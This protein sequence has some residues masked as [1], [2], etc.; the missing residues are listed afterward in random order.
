MSRPAHRVSVFTFRFAERSRLALERDL[1]GTVPGD[2]L[3]QAIG[4]FGELLWGEETRCPA[5]EVDEPK[6]TI[7]HHCQLADHR[8]FAAQRIDIALDFD[9]VDVGEDF[10]VAELTS[11]ATKRDVQVQ[12]QRRV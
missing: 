4:Q 12:A 1:F 8:D 6:R 10:E 11:F 5:A 3:P 2:V 7:P 9:R